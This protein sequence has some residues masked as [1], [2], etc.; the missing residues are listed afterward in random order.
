MV[1]IFEDVVLDLEA[2]NLPL[3]ACGRHGCTDHLSVL[4]MHVFAVDDAW[5]KT[6]SIG[7]LSLYISRIK[8]NDLAS[9]R[10]FRLLVDGNVNRAMSAYTDDLGRHF[11]VLLEELIAISSWMTK[12]GMHLNHYLYL[13]FHE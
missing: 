12:I 1:K 9:E 2:L 11:E 10:S 6:F 5:C 7:L 3:K 13:P 4:N 8:W